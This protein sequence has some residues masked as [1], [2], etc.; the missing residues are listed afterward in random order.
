MSRRTSLRVLRYPRPRGISSAKLR[1][2]C[3]CTTRGIG[4][5]SGLSPPWSRPDGF[6]CLERQLEPHPPEQAPVTLSR[7]DDRLRRSL[8]RGRRPLRN[9]LPM[10]G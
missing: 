5:A 2:R 9:P 6:R 3:A 8:N 4:K 10:N 7:T 1:H